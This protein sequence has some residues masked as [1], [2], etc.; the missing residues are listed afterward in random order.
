MKM[1]SYQIENTNKKTDTLKKK[2]R[3]SGIEKCN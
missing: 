1:V 3:N 2:N